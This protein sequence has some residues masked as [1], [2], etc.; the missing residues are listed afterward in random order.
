MRHDSGALHSQ[1]GAAMH[2]AKMGYFEANTWNWAVSSFLSTEDWEAEVKCRHFS[3]PQMK[4]S[5]QKALCEVFPGWLWFVDSVPEPRKQRALLDTLIGHEA[6]IISSSRNPQVVTPLPPKTFHVRE[7]SN[8]ISCLHCKGRREGMGGMVVFFFFSVFLVFDF[9]WLV[10]GVSGY[11]VWFCFCLV[12]CCCCLVLV[13][14]CFLL[15][16]LLLFQ[17]SL[18]F[19]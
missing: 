16:L 18:L 17:A 2:L 7:I 8:K 5:V 1:K 15:F 11:A 6:L 4:C 12:C 3:S 19:I 9:G 10:G 14:S 13:L